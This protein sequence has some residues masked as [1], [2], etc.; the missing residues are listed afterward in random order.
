[1]F[2]P[3]HTHFVLDMSLYVKVRAGLRGT[4]QNEARFTVL[5]E[6]SLGIA[7][8]ELA[9]LQQLPRTRQTTSLMADCREGHPGCLCR[10][11]KMLISTSR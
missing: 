1:M 7:R 10:I 2:Q 8:I 4:K 5:L 3:V 11:P 6:I 9:G